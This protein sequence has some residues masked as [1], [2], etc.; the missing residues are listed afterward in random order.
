LTAAGIILIW[1]A[2]LYLSIGT[3]IRLKDA[4]RRAMTNNLADEVAEDVEDTAE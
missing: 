3:N 1:I 4:I 2:S